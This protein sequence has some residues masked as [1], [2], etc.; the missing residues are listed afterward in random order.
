MKIKEL[1]FTYTPERSSLIFLMVGDLIQE[2]QAFSPQKYS[3]KIVSWQRVVTQLSFYYLFL[4]IKTKAQVKIRYKSLISRFCPQQHRRWLPCSCSFTFSFFLHASVFFLPITKTNVSHVL[5]PQL[6]RPRLWRPRLT[7]ALKGHDSEGHGSEGHGSEGHGSEGHGSEGH[8]SEGHGSEGHGSEGHGS[9]GHG[10]EGHGSEGHGSEGHGSEG[11]G[12]EGFDGS[13]GQAT[14]LKALTALSDAFVGSLPLK[15]KA[16]TAFSDAFAAPCRWWGRG[17]V[18]M[19]LS[20]VVE[21]EMQTSAQNSQFWA[22]S[23][24]HLPQPVC[25]SGLPH[26]FFCFC[27]CSYL[28]AS[29]LLH[30]MR[31][32]I[33]FH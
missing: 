32:F 18:W 14:S 30:K 16:L 12:S 24:S 27:F 6:W 9:E 28:D 21:G 15:T 8:G 31:P 5:P 7:T 10:S 11:H 26:P 25:L 23:V 29:Y 13:E 3:L 17:A 2:V 1:P 19:W 20:S 22:K 33:Y 4:K